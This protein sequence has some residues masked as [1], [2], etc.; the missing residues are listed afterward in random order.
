MFTEAKAFSLAILGLL[1]IVL[2]VG[3]FVWQFFTEDRVLYHALGAWGV[4]GVVSCIF[5]AWTSVLISKV[6]ELDTRIAKLEG[7][8]KEGEV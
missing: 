4:A 5:S 8:P 3:C 2:A 1:S 7:E 6:H